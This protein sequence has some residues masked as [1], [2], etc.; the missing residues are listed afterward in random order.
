MLSRRRFGWKP[1]G[2]GSYKYP[3]KYYEPNW[4]SDEMYI[5]GTPHHSSW[6]P[7]MIHELV[8]DDEEDEVHPPAENLPAA[9]PPSKKRKR[10]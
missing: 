2:W 1:P 7:G 8:S 5:Q 6:R 4:F 10:N 3:N 9:K